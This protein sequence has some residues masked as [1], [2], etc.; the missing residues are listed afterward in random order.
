MGLDSS[1]E[2]TFAPQIRGPCRD[3]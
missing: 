2:L 3:S 1:L